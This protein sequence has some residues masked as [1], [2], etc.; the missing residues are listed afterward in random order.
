[1]IYIITLKKKVSSLYCFGNS[2]K[3]YYY[4]NYKNF[5][6]KKDYEKCIKPLITNNKIVIGVYLRVYDMNNYLGWFKNE[7]I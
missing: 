4:N 5:F 3:S 2:N 7:M 1:M 6:Y